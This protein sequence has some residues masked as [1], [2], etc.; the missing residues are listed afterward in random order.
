MTETGL[1]GVRLGSGLCAQGRGPWGVVEGM[2]V[3]ASGVLMQA[4]SWTAASCV[5]TDTYDVLLPR[6][7][8]GASLQHAPG[9]LYLRTLPP[10][11]LRA[12]LPRELRTVRPG[13]SVLA[14]CMWG[15]R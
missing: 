10:W 1:A 7:C 14:P 15:V 8:P 2:A 6:Y 4:S 3:D 11:G 5:D 9:P 13:A 12:L